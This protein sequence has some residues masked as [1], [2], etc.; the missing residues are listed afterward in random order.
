MNKI[1][2]TSLLAAAA[3]A[4]TAVLAGS[5]EGSA[6]DAWLTGKVETVFTLNSHLSPFAIDTDV[7]QGVVHLTGAVESKVDRDLAGALA[8]EVDGVTKVDNDLIVDS[9]KA[10][11]HKDKASGE[12]RGFGTWVDDATTT[13]A[14][15]SRL[16]ANGN[17]K[18]L[19]ID[20]DTRN[21]VVTLSGRVAS[22]EVR[23]LAEKLALMAKDVHEVHNNLVVDP[24]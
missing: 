23:Q 13:A 15:K 12:K 6:R 16:I 24:E 2:L 21:D 9:K 8:A 7:D 14:V 10:T 11:M 3:L 5:F 20:V 17:T 1:R 19:Q 18:G 22:D 4:S